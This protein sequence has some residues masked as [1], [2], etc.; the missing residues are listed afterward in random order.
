MKNPLKTL[1]LLALGLLLTASLARAQI[2]PPI[3]STNGSGITTATGTTTVSVTIGPEAGF[4]IT[5]SATPL[6]ETGSNFKQFTG[7]TGL[8]Y[9]VRTTASGGG[10]SITL[11]VTTDFSPAGGPSVGKP[12]S[13]GDALTYT[14]T[15]ASPGRACTG[16][17]TASTVSQTNVATF[18]TDVHT[19]AGGSAASIA[20][21][22][23]NDPKY[24][25]GTYNATV[26]FTISAS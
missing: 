18:G 23:N 20:W 4:D 9:T 8:S 5:D 21:T 7:H 25:T 10:G 3:G 13:P 2:V 24:K 19:G 1:P 14:C 12:P 16:T 17:Q 26:T 6:R 11:K 15:V 22:L